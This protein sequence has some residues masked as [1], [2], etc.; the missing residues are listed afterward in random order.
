MVSAVLTERMG[1]GENGL[2][3]YLSWGSVLSHHTW[4]GTPGAETLCT[5][6]EDFQMFSMRDFG[7]NKIR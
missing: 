5:S 6:A 1:T 7:E 4:S 3:V 2:R